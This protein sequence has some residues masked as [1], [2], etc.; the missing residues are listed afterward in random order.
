MSQTARTRPEASDQ[1]LNEAYDTAL[2]DLDGVVYAGGN[3]IANA[4]ASLGT[5]RSG[6]CTSRMSRTMRCVRPMRWRS[7]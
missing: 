4:V 1:A 2:L 3:A 5:A 7:I 6:G